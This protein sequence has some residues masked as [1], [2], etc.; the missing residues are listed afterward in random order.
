MKAR[1]PIVITQMG[2]I[3]GGRL[4]GWRYRFLSFRVAHVTLAGFPFTELQVMARCSAPNWPFPCEIAL[5]PDHYMQ[6]RTVPGDRAKRLQA[7]P[8]IANAYLLAGVNAPAWLGTD[9]PM[10]LRAAVRAGTRKPT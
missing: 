9:K 8:L 4:D 6:L 7:E 3:R 1:R 10:T 5:R 2:R